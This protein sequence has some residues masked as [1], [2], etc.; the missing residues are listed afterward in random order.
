MCLFYPLLLPHTHPGN[1]KEEEKH[2]PDTPDS[3]DTVKAPA[4]NLDGCG[5]TVCSARREAAPQRRSTADGCRRR[6]GGAKA[7][8]LHAEYERKD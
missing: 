6:C 5:A 8:D 2:T 1:K 7:A 4:G 3:Q